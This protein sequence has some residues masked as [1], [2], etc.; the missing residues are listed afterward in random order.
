MFEVS[1][2]VPMKNV[3][4]MEYTQDEQDLA[5]KTLSNLVKE[6]Q[7]LRGE[8]QQAQEF[9]MRLLISDSFEKTNNSILF[10]DKA[11]VSY[12]ED[13]DKVL[14]HF[15]FNF[16]RD[17]FKGDGVYQQEFTITIKNGTRFPSIGSIEQVRD[18]IEQLNKK[19][20]S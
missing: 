7:E 5:L 13:W 14:P 19:L 11:P 3:A 16:N 18:R 9:C 1:V 10:T 12:R 2:I 20:S 17:N 15:F 8:L 4:N 6:N